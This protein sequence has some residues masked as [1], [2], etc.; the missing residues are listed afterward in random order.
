MIISQGSRR[1]GNRLGENPGERDSRVLKGGWGEDPDRTDSAGL[2][3][4]REGCWR[5][6]KT[7]SNESDGERGP[8]PAETY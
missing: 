3:D 6:K 5:E 2:L 4:R 7:P 8:S 1:K